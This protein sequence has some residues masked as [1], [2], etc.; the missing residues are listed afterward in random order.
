M[1]QKKKPPRKS[2]A[3]SGHYNCHYRRASVIADTE[4]SGVA[5]GNSIILET[6]PTNHQASTSRNYS[7]DFGGGGAAL[8]HMTTHMGPSRSYNSELGGAA[9]N[10]N[11]Q[12]VQIASPRI[13]YNPE[14]EESES[15]E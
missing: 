2:P 3:T 15:E 12:M 8:N 9:R 11:A 5:G 4:D 14:I 10:N 13:P 1:F 6:F 7:T